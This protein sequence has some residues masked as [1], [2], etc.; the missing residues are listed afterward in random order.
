MIPRID[1]LLQLWAQER[2]SGGCGNGGA[3]MLAILMETRGEIIRST[4]SRDLLGVTGEIEL[5]YH[6]RLPLDLQRVVHEHYLNRTSTEAQ[7]LAFCGC[8][9]RTFYRRLHA[10]HAM[11]DGLL[12]ERAA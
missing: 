11:I 2:R 1:D 9:Q 3:S 12:M 6:K 4:G 8:S 5:I 10:A 7:K